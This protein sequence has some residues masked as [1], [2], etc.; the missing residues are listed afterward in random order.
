MN[1]QLEY[2][3]KRLHGGLKKIFHML[4]FS[5][6]LRFICFDMKNLE[7]DVSTDL[8]KRHGSLQRWSVPLI[9]Q[10]PLGR[11]RLRHHCTNYQCLSLEHF[12]L[13]LSTHLFFPDDVIGLE[14]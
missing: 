11:D 12:K 8:Q 13:V 7:N 10:L 3:C 5:K 1:V 14:P 6:V 9:H 4:I 2:M